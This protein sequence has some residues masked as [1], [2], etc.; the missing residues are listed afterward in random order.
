MFKYY[1]ITFHFNLSTLLDPVETL[2]IYILK[3]PLSTN[4]IY[5]LS[6]YSDSFYCNILISEL[7]KFLILKIGDNLVHVESFLCSIKR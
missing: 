3:K 5:T 4:I 6:F 2:K 1:T 7:K